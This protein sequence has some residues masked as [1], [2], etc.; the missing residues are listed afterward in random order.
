MKK[1]VNDKNQ[2]TDMYILGK[3]DIVYL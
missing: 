3:R 2:I 1:H